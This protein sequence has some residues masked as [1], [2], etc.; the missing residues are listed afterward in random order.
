MSLVNFSSLALDI[1]DHP[2]QFALGLQGGVGPHTDDDVSIEPGVDDT[3]VRIEPQ[4]DELVDHG[5]G[6]A[7]EPVDRAD[8]NAGKE[9]GEQHEWQVL[10]H[11]SGRCRSAVVCSWVQVRLQRPLLACLSRRD[12]RSLRW[13]L[14]ALLGPH[15]SRP[16]VH[17]RTGGC[18]RSRPQIHKK[19]AGISRGWVLFAFLGLGDLVK[20][21]KST[22]EISNLRAV[23]TTCHGHCRAAQ[24]SAENRS[25]LETGRVLECGSQGLLF[26]LNLLASVF[27]IHSGIYFL[28]SDHRGAAADYRGDHKGGASCARFHTS[29]DAKDLPWRDSPTMRNCGRTL[30]RRHQMWT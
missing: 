1:G 11:V 6:L 3:V 30:M 13:S 21:E 8:L 17:A 19:E 12:W 2:T 28:R 24:S 26:V 5:S 22:L 23:P 25:A 29:Q 27:A 20:S 9:E 7:G 18:F 14:P 16:D 4:L 15:R 10:S